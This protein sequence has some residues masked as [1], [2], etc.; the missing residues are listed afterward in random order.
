METEDEWIRVPRELD[1]IRAETGVRRIGI[2]GHRPVPFPQ[3]RKYAI[4][5]ANQGHIVR[6][7]V[8]V[9]LGL[10]L[11]ADV[12]DEPDEVSWDEVRESLL[13]GLPP[14][15]FNPADNEEELWEGL[16]ETLI[17]RHGRSVDEAVEMVNRH[18]ALVAWPENFDVMVH[19][20][21]TPTFADAINAR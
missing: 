13:P 1:R 2:A 15:D 6:C 8:D 17:S 21:L 10:I 12:E 9:W 11:I 20:G 14:F 19:D 4:D 16:V 3:G 5:L 18:H 7:R